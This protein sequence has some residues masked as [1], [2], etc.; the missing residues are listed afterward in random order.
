MTNSEFELLYSIKS[1]L[2]SNVIPITI[3]IQMHPLNTLLSFF[4]IIA[5]L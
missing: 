1:I 2:E 5:F 4:S 3:N